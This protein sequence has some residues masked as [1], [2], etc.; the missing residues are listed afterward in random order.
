MNLPHAAFFQARH[1][2][3]VFVLLRGLSMCDSIKPVQMPGLSQVGSTAL[4]EPGCAEPEWSQK[5]KSWDCDLRF[6]QELGPQWLSVYALFYWMGNSDSGCFIF[7][8]IT[9][10]YPLSVG[11][12]PHTH[13]QKSC[14]N[15]LQHVWNS[16]RWEHCAPTDQSHMICVTSLSLSINIYIYIYIYR[17]R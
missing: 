9:F 17:Y 11:P 16:S 15:H 7:H 13:N 6:N 4:S 8:C 3:P 14:H 10:L 5:S 12:E 2:L 1:H